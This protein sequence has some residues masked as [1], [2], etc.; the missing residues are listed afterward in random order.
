MTSYWLLDMFSPENQASLGNAT[1]GDLGQYTTGGLQ[2]ADNSR[3][4]NRWLTTK[5]SMEP[6]K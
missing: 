5:E 2:A 1:N 6:T 3:V 4:H